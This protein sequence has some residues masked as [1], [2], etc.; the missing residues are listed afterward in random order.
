MYAEPFQALR[1]QH[2]VNHHL[3]IE[4]LKSDR[5]VPD[6]WI[7]PVVNRQ[8]YHMLRIDQ[9][10]D[11]GLVS[12]HRNKYKITTLIILCTLSTYFFKSEY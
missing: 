5:I 12:T 6:E 9:G 10:L 8:W 3:D 7:D 11:R 2:L 4:M 1:F